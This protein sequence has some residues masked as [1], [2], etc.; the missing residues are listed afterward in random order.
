MRAVPST[1]TTSTVWS[2]ATVTCGFSAT[3]RAL[4]LFGAHPKTKVDVSGTQT[5]HT[6][7]ACGRPAA[8]AVTTHRFF[9]ASSRSSAHDHGSTPSRSSGTP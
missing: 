7:M 3:L 1:T 4:R 8:D 9:E 6:G 5:P 2:T